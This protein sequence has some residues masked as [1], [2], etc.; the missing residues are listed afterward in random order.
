MA[1]FVILLL[2]F[3][4]VVDSE[5]YRQYNGTLYAMPLPIFHSEFNHRFRHVAD[6]SSTL[7]TFNSI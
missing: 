6:S 3:D 5:E 1:T 7:F 4:A 2:I